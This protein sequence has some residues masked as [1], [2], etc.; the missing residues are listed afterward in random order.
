MRLLLDSHREPATGTDGVK[1]PCDP[2]DT[3]LNAVS[4]LQTIFS[5]GEQKCVVGK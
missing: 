3:E 5:G 2:S 1:K 4:M